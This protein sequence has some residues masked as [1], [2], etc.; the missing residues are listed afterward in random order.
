[1]YREV[2]K[3]QPDHSG[4]LTNLAVYLYYKH[5]PRT[6]AEI[7]AAAANETDSGE[8]SV[9]TPASIKRTEIVDEVRQLLKRAAATNW[10]RRNHLCHYHL[11]YLLE[12][13]DNATEA[14]KMEYSKALM[15]NNKHFPSHLNLGSLLMVDGLTG[16]LSPKL[17][18]TSA[19]R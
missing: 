9:S 6:L 11:A 4:A 5:L 3:L 2:L 14:A 7:Q 18:T 1:M 13:E 16:A 17:Y 12:I 8:K 15:I 10:N 19:D